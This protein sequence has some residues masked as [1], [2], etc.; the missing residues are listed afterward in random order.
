L[1]DILHLA[2]AEAEVETVKFLLSKNANK[3][4]QDRWGNTSYHE[5][6][7]GAQEIR[8]GEEEDSKSLEL[9]EC[10]EICELLE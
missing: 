5:T 7:K 1:Y 4:P 8:E 2:A 3:D 6:Y 9:K 10:E